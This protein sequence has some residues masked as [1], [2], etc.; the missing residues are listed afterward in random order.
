VFRS[1]WYVS[2]FGALMSLWVMFQISQAY[3]VLSLVVMFLLYVTVSWLNEDMRGLSN[4]VQGA[5]FQLSRRLQVFLQKSRKQEQDSWRPAIVCLSRSSFQRLGAFDLMSWISHRYG[6]GTYIHFL[7][8]YVSRASKRQADED[9][10]RLLELAHANRSNVYLDTMISPSYT[11][12]IAQL[13]QLP[14]ISGKENN[15]VLFEFSKDHPGDLEDIVDNYQLVASLDFDVGILGSSSRAFGYRRQLH[16]WLT[17]GDYENAG[18]MI[19]LAYILLGHPDW[20]GGVIKVFSVLPSNHLEEERERL[21]RLIRTGRL[22]ISASNVELLPQEAG[23]DRRAIVN[24]RSR[25]ADLVILGFRGEAVRRAGAD[26]FKGYDG[27]GNLLF[28]NTLKEI[29]IVRGE[30]EVETLK[31][32]RPAPAPGTGTTPPG[33]AT[34]P[35]TVAPAGDARPEPEDPG[36]E[37]TPESND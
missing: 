35:V 12:A 13:L 33:V 30:D 37:P 14:G 5:I 15:M 25:D 2:A 23:R 32:T 20:K 19:L 26:V 16:V 34:G 17:P 4:I 21:F 8:G 1:H 36:R 29:E 7:S 18:L 10:R 9:L 3:A 6:F 24:E 27:V 11:T 22:P 31:M 28:I